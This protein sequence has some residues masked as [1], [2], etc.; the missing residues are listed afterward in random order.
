MNLRNSNQERLFGYLSFIIYYIIYKHICEC[1]KWRQCQQ[2]PK[3]PTRLLE[4]LPGWMITSSRG[5]PT[6]L[7]ECLSGWG[8]SI[9]SLTL[10]LGH[11]GLHMIS[12]S[13]LSILTKTEICPQVLIKL[14]NVTF[15]ESPPFSC[16]VFSFF[17]H[18]TG[19]VSL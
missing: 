5:F 4:S 15:Y 10:S 16:Y 11:A 18:L 14:H 7:R 3:F 2:N 13:F 9:Q 1:F 17:R 6:L 19:S 8:F 12:P